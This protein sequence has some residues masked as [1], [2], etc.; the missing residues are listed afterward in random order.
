MTRN[1]LGKYNILIDKEIVNLSKFDLWNLIEFLI[2]ISQNIL[3]LIWNKNVCIYN[4]G[5]NEGTL[6]GSFII[7]ILIQ[8]IFY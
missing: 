6:I 3:N 7:L 4:P 5:L 1:F 8:R 2:M